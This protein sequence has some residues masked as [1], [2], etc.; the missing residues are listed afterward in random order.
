MAREGRMVIAV[1]IVKNTEEN[2]IHGVYHF[3]WVKSPEIHK[4]F[5]FYRLVSQRE[6]WSGACEMSQQNLIR[7]KHLDHLAI[8]SAITHLFIMQNFYA[9]QVS[10]ILTHTVHDNENGM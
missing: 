9:S 5:V 10:E 3:W 8:H 6:F 7:N 2:I 4:P 1:Y